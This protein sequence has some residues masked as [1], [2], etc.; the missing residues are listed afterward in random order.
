M[1][2]GN[3]RTVEKKRKD[4]NRFHDLPQPNPKLL[5]NM[6]NRLIR[7]ALAFDMHKS[8]LDHQQL[9]SQ[10]NPEQRVI[11]EEVMESVHNKKRPVLLCL[12]ARRHRKDLFIQDYHFKAKIR[13]ED[14]IASLLLPAGRTAHSRFVILLE[15]LENST[16][17]IK[18]NTHLAELYARNFN[19]WVL[20]VGDGKLPTKIKDGE[21]EPTWIEIPKK[22]L[23]NSSNSPIEQIVAETYP[24]FIKRQRDDVYL[25][26]RAILTPRNDD[27]DAI[28]AYM[29]DKLEV[30]SLTY[31]SADEICKAS[32]DT[33]DQQH[34]YLIKFLYTLNFPG[35]P[36][37]LYALSLKKELP[38]ML[39]RNV[40][41]SQGLCNG[42]RLIITTLGEFVLK[43]EILTGTNVGDT[44][45]IH[46]IIL[47]STQSK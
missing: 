4:F 17:G 33:L 13:K 24:K 31:N 23:I 2:G 44:I 35:I 14:R 42:T 10:L 16:C 8:K 25:R 29:F 19:Q 34:L 37:P 3:S 12:W 5:T 39:L 1:F 18:Q 36:P 30:E 27:A 11:Y 21:D 43:A 9:H 6:D 15:L 22:F 40:N 7:E 38:I 45:I 46:W 41:P 26:E 20:V 47:T 28:N 32:N